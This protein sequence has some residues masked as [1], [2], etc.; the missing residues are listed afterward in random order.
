MKGIILFAHGARDPVWAAPFLRL[1][2]MV[3]TLQPEA[4]VAL[5]YLELMTPD[6]AAAV[7]DM[8]AARVT[9]IRIVPLFLGPGTHFRQDFPALLAELRQRYPQASLTTTPVLGDSDVVLQ[10]IA[11]WITASAMSAPV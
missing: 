10:A 5:A 3:S 1:Q 4:T 11:G 7:S 9:D 2:R 6:L 8:C